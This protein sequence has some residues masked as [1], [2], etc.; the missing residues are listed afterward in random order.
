MNIDIYMPRCDVT[1]K[2]G[3][4]P[5]KRGPVHPV[6]QYWQ[7]FVSLLKRRHD[8]LGHK[9]RVIEIPLWQLTPEKVDDYSIDASLIYIPHKMIENWIEDERVLFYMQM[10]VP[11]IFSIDSKGWCAS[12]SVY[13]I[14]P[15]EDCDEYLLDGFNTLSRRIFSNET[16]FEQPS[17]KSK[18]PYPDDYLFFPCQILMMRQLDIIAL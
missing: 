3:P 17:N 12:A 9:T 11:S 15:F 16:K 5:Q 6:K 8:E 4:I 18:L 13:P 10:V 7:K 14:R 1:F 2:K